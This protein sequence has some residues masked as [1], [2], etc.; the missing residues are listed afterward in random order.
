M[1][2]WLYRRHVF[3]VDVDTGLWV[4]PAPRLLM[5]ASEKCDK[6]PRH[7]IRTTGMGFAGFWAASSN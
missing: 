6:S 4:G 3:G 2:V 1:T 5:W 7:W